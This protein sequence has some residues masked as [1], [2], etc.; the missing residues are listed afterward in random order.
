[1]SI[2]N[3]SN[4]P[5][6]NQKVDTSDT[7]TRRRDR[8]FE[9]SY[10]ALCAAR[11]I[12]VNPSCVGSLSGQLALINTLRQIT[13]SLAGLAHWSQ[14]DPVHLEAISNLQAHMEEIRRTLDREG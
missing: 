14:I 2:P 4:N 8:D 11:N 9:S 1:M 7:I 5:T 13:R 6:P 3:T 10:N 12:F